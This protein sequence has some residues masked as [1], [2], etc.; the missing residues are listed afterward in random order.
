MQLANRCTQDADT[1][2]RSVGAACRRCFSLLTVFLALDTDTAGGGTRSIGE[3]GGVSAA[4]T[5]LH[6]SS[7]RWTSRVLPDLDNDAAAASTGP[8]FDTL[9]ASVQLANS[10]HT[11][12]NQFTR[13]TGPVSLRSMQPMLLTTDVQLANRCTQDADTWDRSVGGSGTGS[14]VE[15]RGVST[16]RTS[17]HDSSQ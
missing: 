5:S 9:S 11:M 6:D 14:V 4:H 3:A 2:D 12:T 7:R 16:A 8:V 15:A 1:R 10:L 13:G 17:L